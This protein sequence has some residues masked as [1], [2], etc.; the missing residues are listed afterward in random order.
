MYI[1]HVT[2][3]LYC[4]FLKLVSLVPRPHPQE[5]KD[6]GILECFLGLAHYHMTEHAPTQIYANNHMI[7]ELAEPR[8]GANVPR[9]FP[10]VAW[11]GLGTR[12]QAGYL[13]KV[14]HVLII[15]TSFDGHVVN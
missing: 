1:L 5:G 4:L 15:H 9:P 7:A 10:R 14:V 2:G 6:L 12:L 11:W 8:I 3:I 13:T